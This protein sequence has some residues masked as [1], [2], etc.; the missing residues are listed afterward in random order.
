MNCPK[1]DKELKKVAYEGVEIEEC[2]SCGGHWLDHREI[3]T[4]IK[5]REETFSPE[6]IKEVMKARESVSLEVRDPDQPLI[7]P[8]CNVPMTRMSYAYAT[9]II[10]DR[11]TKC[12][13]IWLDKDELKHIQIIMEEQEK[14][15]PEKMEKIA[16]VLEQIKQKYQ[17]RR[18]EVFGDAT[19]SS[20][21]AKLPGMRSL[22][23]FLLGHF[24]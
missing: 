22:V 14:S 17:S 13:G 8:S 10:I 7:C 21:I 1:C 6:E 19:Q 11:C 20:F 24:D 16:P 18:D 4:I 3:V 23:R 2:E 12:H 15:F 9:G 5:T